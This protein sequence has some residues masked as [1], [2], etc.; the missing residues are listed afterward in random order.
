M[1]PKTVNVQSALARIDAPWQPHRLATVNNQ[2]VKV[3][4]LLGSFVWH[5]HDVDELFYVLSGT[6]H[7]DV[8]ERDGD[9]SGSQK[10]DEDQDK[11]SL[12]HST[13]SLGPGDMIVIPAHMRH[14]PHCAAEVQALLF[15][16]RGVVNTGDAGGDMTS[17]VK[18]LA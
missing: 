15:E 12:P 4:K 13:V 5:A 8:R 2:E 14:R 17:A 7:I 10:G 1:A 18:E 16:P 6:L 3:V 9:E 11:D